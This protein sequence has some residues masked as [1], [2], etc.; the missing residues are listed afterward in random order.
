[1]RWKGGGG[2]SLNDRR[3]SEGAEGAAA[4]R[5][6]EAN[7]FN[8]SPLLIEK[9]C[10]H[11]SEMSECERGEGK[12]TTALSRGDDEEDSGPARELVSRVNVR[13]RPRGS[14]R[15]TGFFNRQMQSGVTTKLVLRG[16]TVHNMN[17]P[18]PLPANSSQRFFPPALSTTRA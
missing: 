7:T 3:I 5:Q 9:V 1:M 17:S 2:G 11:L 6:S 4:Q 16:Q 8:R 15:T 18:P 14:E 13:K 10:F 12:E